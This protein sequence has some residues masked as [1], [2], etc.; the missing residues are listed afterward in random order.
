MVPA[1]RLILTCIRKSEG[2]NT[3]GTIIVPLWQLASYLTELH[4]NSGSFRI[5]IVVSFLLPTQIVIHKG[6]GNNG[7]FGR[8]Y[9]I[10]R[11]FGLEDMILK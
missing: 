10:F 5:L 11:N 1:P 4:D 6:Y 2:E 3:D 8:E 7:I 9:L